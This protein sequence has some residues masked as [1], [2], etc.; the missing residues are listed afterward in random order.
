MQDILAGQIDLIIVQ[1][2]V[3]TPHM[4]SGAVKALANMSPARSAVL[5]I[6]PTADEQGVKGLYVGGWFGFFAPKG[7]PR[8]IVARLNNAMVQALA[9]PTVKQRFADLGLDL[10]TREQQSPEGLAAFHK[11]EI[12][13]WYPIIRAAGIK[14]E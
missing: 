3:A 4:K 9:D 12:E 6:I 14:A 7:T 1:A 10:A 8:E 2:A 13:K 5:P 11:A